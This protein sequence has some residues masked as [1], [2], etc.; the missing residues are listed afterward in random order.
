MEAQPPLT[1]GQAVLT[2]VAHS[3]DLK[4]QRKTVLGDLMVIHLLDLS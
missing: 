3:Q 2:S 4:V 1:A